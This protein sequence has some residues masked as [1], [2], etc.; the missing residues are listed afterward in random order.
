MGFKL[1]EVNTVVKCIKSPIFISL[2]IALLI[3]ITT[4]IVLCLFEFPFFIISVS[5]NNLSNII[6]FYS[7]IITALAV[8]ITLVLGGSIFYMFNYSKIHLENEVKE[9]IDSKAQEFVDKSTSLKEIITDKTAKIEARLDL[10]IEE[11]SEQLEIDINIDKTTLEL[12]DNKNKSIQQGEKID[13]K[14]S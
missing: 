5:K 13:G 3:S 14:N 6:S 10:L 8:L 2:V 4:N 11:L 12:P 1:G 9:Q 7:T